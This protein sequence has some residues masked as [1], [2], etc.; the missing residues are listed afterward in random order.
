[1]EAALF[2]LFDPVGSYL[3]RLSQGAR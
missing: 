2:V 3:E 1:V